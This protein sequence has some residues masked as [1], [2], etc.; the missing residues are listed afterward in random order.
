MAECRGMRNTVVTAVSLC[1]VM[2]R[3][4]PGIG[5]CA[6]CTIN[7]RFNTQGGILYHLRTKDET[8]VELKDSNKNGNVDDSL[9]A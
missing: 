9:D 4:A 1:V 2:L 8:A 3:N 6:L 7:T 5:M